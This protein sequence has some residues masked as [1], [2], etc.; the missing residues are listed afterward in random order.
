MCLVGTRLNACS[1]WRD[2]I[3]L[4]TYFYVTLYIYLYQRQEVFNDFCGDKYPLGPL[5]H[6]NS[7]W[8]HMPVAPQGRRVVGRAKISVE[9]G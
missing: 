4:R 6:K 2:D 7:A 8:G 9:M 5:E 3:Q 1:W